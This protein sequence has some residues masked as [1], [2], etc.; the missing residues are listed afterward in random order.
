MYTTD[1]MYAPHA[2]SPAYQ[3]HM[4]APLGPILRAGHDVGWHP[5]YKEGTL[6]HFRTTHCHPP[7]I[8]WY[9]KN[10]WQPIEL[11]SN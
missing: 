10:L 1:R 8:L 11:A 2:G 3:V 9:L 7:C 5:L 6:V 4:F